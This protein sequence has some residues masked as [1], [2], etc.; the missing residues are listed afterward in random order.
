[1][2]LHKVPSTP[3]KEQDPFGIF[4]QNGV[5]KEEEDALQE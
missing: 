2:P 3:R 1:M 5:L 4:T